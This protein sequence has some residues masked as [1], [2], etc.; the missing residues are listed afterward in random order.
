MRIG[1]LARRSGLTTKTLRFYEQAR[2]LPEP[3]RRDSGYRDYED[4][5]LD[6]L[7]FVKAA[8]AAGLSLAEVRDVIAVREQEGAPCD[9]VVSLLGAHAD[10]LDRRIAE[11]VSLRDEVRRLRGRAKELDLSRCSA[12]TV[13]DII[14]TDR[15]AA[16][17]H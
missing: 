9:H 2:V 15:T 17:A 14:P 1:E 4:V 10:H 8:Q 11:L 6:R 7:A 13:C 3:A 5:A 16:I 12:S